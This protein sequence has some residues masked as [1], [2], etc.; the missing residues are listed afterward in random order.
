MPNKSDD[1]EKAKADVVTYASEYV[2]PGG[3]HIVKG[4]YKQ[5][6]L[7]VVAG[8][9]AKYFFGLPGLLLVSANSIVKARTGRHLF[10]HLNLGG[11]STTNRDADDSLR[12]GP[13]SR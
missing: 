6:G 3:S 7:H 4:D 13:E 9:A 11:S 12:E 5:A 8:F 2:V 1:F 10:E